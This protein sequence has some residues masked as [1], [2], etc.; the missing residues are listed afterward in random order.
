MRWSRVQQRARG[1]AVVTTLLALALSACSAGEAPSASATATA[2]G[3][4]TA[5]TSV[6]AAL[7]FSCGYMPTGPY[8][9][10]GD[11]AVS[12][13]SRQMYYPAWQVPEGAP[14]QPLK[15]ASAGGNPD[16]GAIPI[17]PGGAPDRY[18]AFAVCNISTSASATLRSVSIRVASFTAHSGALAGWSPCKD[19]PFDAQRQ[20]T[21]TLG[22]GGDYAAN[23]YLLAAFPH[24][25]SVG[26]SVI[27]RV[28]STSPP[29]PDDPNPYPALPLTL[30]A[31]HSAVM[32]ITLVAP[33]SPGTYT[34]AFGVTAG[35]AASTYFSTTSPTLY[36]PITQE[37]SGQ[38]C[39]TPAMQS[40]IPV[41]SQPTSYI[42]P[43]AS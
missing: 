2:P 14:D 21:L 43:P 4:S 18:F 15:L 38:N 22:C 6:V 8:T 35:S 5:T 42:C 12:P 19:G 16:P 25:A 26:D 17:G 30:D 29:G 32:A 34:F 11:L 28:T 39:L 10:I 1:V 36:A 23:E 24:G 9:R 13:V 3:A 20:S 33:A 40:Q 7:P 41:A 27:A 37:W 31:G